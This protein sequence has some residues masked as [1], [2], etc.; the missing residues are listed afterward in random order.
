M[1]RESS[2]DKISPTISRKTETIQTELDVQK[3]IVKAFEEEDEEVRNID[4]EMEE[5]RKRRDTAKAK[6]RERVGVAKV[7]GMDD[8]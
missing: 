7:Y 5:L 4:L 8:D 1:S 3:E 6:R 2:P